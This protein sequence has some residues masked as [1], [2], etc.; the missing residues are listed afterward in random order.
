MLQAVL[1]DDQERTAAQEYIADVT[2]IIA[3]KLI[4][5]EV[6]MHSELKRNRRVQR[7]DTRA[8]K[9]IVQDIIAKRRKRGNRGGDRN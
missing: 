9:T 2:A 6:P 5:T 3:Q 7:Y 8:A 1:E 4:R